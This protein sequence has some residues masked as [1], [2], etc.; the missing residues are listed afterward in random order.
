MQLVMKKKEEREKAKF[1]KLVITK[2]DGTYFD[3]F[4]FWNQFESQIDKCDLPQVSKFFN[5][6]ELAIQK[7]RLLIDSLRFT[8]EGCT[9]AKNVF[10]TKYGKPSE[11]A[12]AHVRNIMSLPQI[13][14]ANPEKIH[15]FSDNLLCSVKALDTMGK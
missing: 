8:S 6:K 7:V 9:R 4:R 1:P 3:W 12:N 2:F 15:D 11:V 14:N 5:L 10:L 13:N